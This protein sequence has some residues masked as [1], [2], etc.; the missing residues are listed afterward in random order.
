[1]N[2]SIFLFLMNGNK[3]AFISKCFMLHMKNN[4]LCNKTLTDKTV[5]KHKFT[6]ALVPWLILAS[7]WEIQNKKQLLFNDY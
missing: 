2:L 7:L 5:I 3:N 6:F 4:I 1:M